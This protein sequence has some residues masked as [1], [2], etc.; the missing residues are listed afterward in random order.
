MVSIGRAESKL[1]LIL[2][3]NLY[4]RPAAPERSKYLSV[5]TSDFCGS[6]EYECNSVTIR[7]FRE[8][9]GA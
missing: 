3:K 2:K 4:I 5:R 7:G 8:K 6:A 9:G 1:A